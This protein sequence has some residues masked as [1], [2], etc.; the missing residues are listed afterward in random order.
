MILYG[1]LYYEQPINKFSDTCITDRD[2]ID[3]INNIRFLYLRKVVRLHFENTISTKDL[4]Y[5][6]ETFK[7]EFLDYLNNNDNRYQFIEGCTE[8]CEDILRY[9][10]KIKKEGNKYVFK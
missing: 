5:N 3:F 10:L 7:Q 8:K 6:L 1:Y 2:I 9:L 4:Y